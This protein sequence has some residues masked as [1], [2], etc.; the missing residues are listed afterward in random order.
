[1]EA[2]SKLQRI[3]ELNRIR[4]QNYYKNH[5]EEINT[6]RRNIY[7][8]GKQKLNPQ[9]EH[10]ENQ[11][12]EKEIYK[13]DFSKSK[14]LSYEEIIYALK[15]LEI[16]DGSRDKYSQDI[17]R[18]M[19]LTE[20]ENFIK[21]LKDYKKI[22]EIINNSKK[23]NG[24]SY[25]VNTRKALFQMILFLIDKLK[26]PISIKVKQQYIQQFEI[27][28]I[29]SND[30]STEKQETAPIYTFKEYLEKVKD[31]YGVISKFYVL[32]K[33]YS[34]ITLRDD[35]ILKIV[36]SIE[37]TNENENFIIIPIKDK[38]TII[39]NNYKTSN[40]YGQIKIKLSTS[41]SN[42]IRDYMLKEKLG[43]NDYLFGNKTL[44]NYVQKMNKTIGINAGINEYRKMSV[45]D[46]LNTQPSPEERQKLAETMRH[47]PVVQVR[48][49]RKNK[50]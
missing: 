13:T 18:L 5:K 38:L 33:L 40:K 28:K 6:K 25:S 41:L 47:S 49:L 48:Y 46:L 20:C 17:K 2:E 3:N 43:Y 37:E 1:M 21:C 32:S 27:Y 4:Q 29:S 42:L 45:T 30:Y 7:N 36:H 12:T 44:S 22:I 50:L 14:T 26:L 19:I 11:F 24:E 35:F 31:E 16:K 39:V 23:S 8:L 34:E 15:T 10:V 9:E